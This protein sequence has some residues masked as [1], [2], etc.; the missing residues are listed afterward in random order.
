MPFTENP[1]RQQALLW[2]M[3]PL[4]SRH[5]PIL[6]MEGTPKDMPL[7]LTQLAHQAPPHLV[8]LWVRITL[9][10]R[11]RVGCFYSEICMGKNRCFTGLLAEHLILAAPEGALWEDRLL[12]LTAGPQ[13]CVTQCCPLAA[14]GAHGRTLGQ[15][16]PLPSEWAPWTCQ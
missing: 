8:A 6:F 1:L 4:T 12:Q 3:S 10:S 2:V 9:G 14:S 11:K 15:G 7:C 13:L 5:F 16:V